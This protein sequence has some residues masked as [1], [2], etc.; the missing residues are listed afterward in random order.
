MT[1]RRTRRPPTGTPGC[2]WGQITELTDGW[3][4]SWIQSEA[5]RL[6]RMVRAEP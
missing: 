4:P 1:L 5:E 6:V 2:K 3:R